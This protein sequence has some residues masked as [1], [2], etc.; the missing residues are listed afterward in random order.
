MCISAPHCFSTLKCINL[1]FAKQS[2][3][4]NSIQTYSHAIDKFL[5]KCNMYNDT[6]AILF[7]TCTHHIHTHIH[8][9]NS[10]VRKYLLLIFQHRTWLIWAMHEASCRVATWKWSP[11]SWHDLCSVANKCRISLRFWSYWRT[12]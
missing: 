10:V 2:Y 7:I 6:L 1:K 8:I 5:Y 12:Q 11:L 4:V 9:T 3:R